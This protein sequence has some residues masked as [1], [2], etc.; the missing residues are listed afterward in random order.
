M[1]GGPGMAHT[2]AMSLSVA[3]EDQDEV[4]RVWNAFLR[5]GAE[6]MMCGWLKDRFGVRWQIVPAEFENMLRAADP[7]TA[8]R[9]TEAMYTMTRLDLAALQEAAWDSSS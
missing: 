8:T 6:P 3:C 4:D 1:N 9:L 7:A 5:E 2:E